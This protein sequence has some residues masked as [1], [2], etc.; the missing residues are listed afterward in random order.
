MTGI[1][2]HLAGTNYLIA[3]KSYWMRVKM[4]YVLH[5]C[6]GF[7]PMWKFDNNFVALLKS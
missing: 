1:Y 6:M 7:Q 5:V 3:M 2:A 4:F